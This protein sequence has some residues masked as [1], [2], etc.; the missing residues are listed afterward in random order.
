MAVGVVDHFQIIRVDHDDR[1]AAELFRPAKQGGQ[2]ILQSAAIVQAGQRIVVA[3]RLDLFSLFDFIRH[4]DDDAENIVAF[5]DFF[6]LDITLSAG[7]YAGFIGNGIFAQV[8]NKFPESFV[9]RREAVDFFLFQRKDFRDLFSDAHPFHMPVVF[10]YTDVHIGFAKDIRHFAVVVQNAFFHS[11]DVT[12]QFRKLDTALNVN[13]L[14]QI[15][16]RYAVKFHVY[17]VDTFD[18]IAVHVACDHIGQNHC[19]GNQAE[20]KRSGR[21][22]NPSVQIMTG[23]DAADVILTDFHKHAV[24]FFIVHIRMKSLIMGGDFVKT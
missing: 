12:A 24:G 23:E 7:K 15:S 6:Q 19:D 10:I 22:R 1:A 17:I 8:G 4:V 11:V 3:F 21:G 14:I 2:P 18:Y 16:L 5:T 13:D 20:R 9:I